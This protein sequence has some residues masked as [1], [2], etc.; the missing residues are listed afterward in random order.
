MATQ[1]ELTAVLPLGALHSHYEHTHAPG[2]LSVA[3]TPPRLQQQSI[4]LKHA[5]HCIHCAALR[6]SAPQSGS[7]YGTV[8]SSRVATGDWHL[9]TGSQARSC[10]VL[11]LPSSNDRAYSSRA[12][13]QS[14]RIR[15]SSCRLQQ[16]IL[17]SAFAGRILT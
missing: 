10:L 17:A 1:R 8:R 7:S 14:P 15:S 2:C 16:R 5:M 6:C 4:A 13:S 3:L 12:A 11:E 9:A